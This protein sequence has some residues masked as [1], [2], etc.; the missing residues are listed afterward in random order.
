[1]SDTSNKLGIIVKVSDRDSATQAM[2]MSGLSALWLGANFLVVA[3]LVYSVASVRPTGSPLTKWLVL[4]GV[5][6]VIVAFLIRAGWHWLVPV[7]SLICAA[8]FIAAIYYG[9]GVQLIVCLLAL[10]LSIAGLRGWVWLMRNRGK[11][12]G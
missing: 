10:G 4:T 5:V 2:K 9:Q 8:A 1:M 12:T 6:L 3:F 7:N 11:T